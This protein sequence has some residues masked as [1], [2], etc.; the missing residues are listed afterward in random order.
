MKSPFRRLRLFSDAGLTNEVM[1][2]ALEETRPQVLQEPPGTLQNHNL[3]ASTSSSV[4]GQ[5]SSG[6]KTMI[7]KDLKDVPDFNN[8][9]GT[10]YLHLG[11]STK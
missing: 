1:H 4:E 9:V 8:A 7:S 11:S 3:C 2:R 5:L 6:T 10:V